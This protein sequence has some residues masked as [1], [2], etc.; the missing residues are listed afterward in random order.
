MP[1][2][3]PLPPGLSPATAA[4]FGLAALGRR[5]HA[6]SLTRRAAVTREYGVGKLAKL[7]S[8]VVPWSVY[9]Y[10][11]LARWLTD[12]LQVSRKT[13]WLY[14]TRDEALPPKHARRLALICRERA[15]AFEVLAADFESLSVERPK[16]R[17]R[18]EKRGG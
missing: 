9:E 5:N 2:D 11:G 18:R 4:R 7:A 3:P 10:P 16:G 15:A 17:I 1:L 14:M 6:R 12:L 8:Q 13:A